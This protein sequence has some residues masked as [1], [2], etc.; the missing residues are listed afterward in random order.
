MRFANSLD[1]LYQGAVCRVDYVK[2][3]RDMKRWS[4]AH[5]Q[6]QIV[7]KTI[8]EDFGNDCLEWLPDEA[9]ITDLCKQFQE[10]ENPLEGNAYR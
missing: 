10:L 2:F 1:W 4:E 7:Q 3:L 6:C 8:A 9:E 5:M